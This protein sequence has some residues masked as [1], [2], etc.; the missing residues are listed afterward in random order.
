MKAFVGA[1]LI[2][3]S[4][5]VI[6]KNHILIVDGANIH[7]IIPNTD[8]NQDLLES[9]EEIYN[10]QGCTILP[11]LIDCHEHVASKNYELITRWNLDEPA[12]TT[13]IRT[14]KVLEDTLQSGYTS[15][16]DAGG[17]DYGYK[18]AIEEGIWQG[19]RLILAISI[20]SQTGGIGDRISGSGHINSI[21]NNPLLPNAVVDGEEQI[22]HKLRELVRCGADVIKIATTGGASSRQGLGP[23]DTSFS[24]SEVRFIIDE[25]TRLNKKVM[26]HALGGPGLRVC[27]EEGVHSIEHGCYLG[28]DPDL[29]KIMAESNMFLVP[30]FTVYDYHKQYS[31]PHVQE[32]AQLLIDKH[33]QSFELAMKNDVKIVAGTDA[34]G[35]V[36]GD[37]ARELELLVENGMSPLNAIKAATGVA[38]ECLTMEDTIGSLTVGHKADL[39][40]MKEDPLK[41][42]SILR[43]RNKIKYV[44]KDGNNIELSKRII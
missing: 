7:S 13:S 30:T 16:R 2:N 4:T 8:E 3:G 12:S 34:G 26:C 29:L 41:N 17:L 5:D 24:R 14:F 6:Q 39:L 23:R 43:D 35:F 15:I 33:R 42:I 22:Q 1:D 21:I 28:E 9:M 11:G 40:I 27:I 38:A 44:F 19:P 37:N 20:M 25:S 32:R 31:A 36:H 10:V 18:L